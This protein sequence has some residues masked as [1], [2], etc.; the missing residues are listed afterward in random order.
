MICDLEVMRPPCLVDGGRSYGMAKFWSYRADN[1]IK[2]TAQLVVDVKGLR[3]V[4]LQPR[5]HK[6]TPFG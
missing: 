5:G 2:G 6:A 4:D 3:F 1:C